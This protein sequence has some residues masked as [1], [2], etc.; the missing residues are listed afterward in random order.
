MAM[1]GVWFSKLSKKKTCHSALEVR[2]NREF[3][4]VNY[5]L[6]SQIIRP[7]GLPREAGVVTTT[8]AVTSL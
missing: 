7:S 6:D 1:L 4:I 8:R 2:A 3:K 5:F